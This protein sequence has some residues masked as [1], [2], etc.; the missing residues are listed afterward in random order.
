MFNKYKFRKNSGGYSKLFQ[1]EKSKLKKIV[2]C[3][4]LIKHVGS[5]AVKGLGGKGILDIVIALPKNKLVFARAKLQE[6]GYAFKFLP[7]ITERDF[8]KKEYIYRK[9]FRMVHLHLTF[10]K[11]IEYKRLIS[12]VEYMNS[13]PEEIKKYEQIKK[14]AVKYAKGDGKKYRTYKDN[15]LKKLTQKALKFD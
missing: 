13:H 2:G 5:T 8:F 11:S 4:A 7:E 3:N 10:E 1:R 14:E 12:F 15:Y 6:A 9:G